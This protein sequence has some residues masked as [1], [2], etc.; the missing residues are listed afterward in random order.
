M[1]LMERDSNGTI[2]NPLLFSVDIFLI[3]DEPLVEGTTVSVGAIGVV[4]P[5]GQD[6]LGDISDPDLPKTYERSVWAGFRGATTAIPYNESTSERVNIVGCFPV[7]LINASQQKI[8]VIKDKQNIPI[9]Q[10]IL[11]DTQGDYSPYVIFPFSTND[12]SKSI[13]FD[14]KKI[15]VGGSDVARQES[16]SKV[17]TWLSIVL[18]VFTVITAFPTLY[19]LGKNFNSDWSIIQRIQK[20]IKKNSP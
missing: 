6:I 20:I 11:W 8:A 3:Y 4:Y 19:E 12:T 17:N 15:H 2:V 14:E 5:E 7:H 18:F 16:Y 10:K 1:P 9:L 13:V